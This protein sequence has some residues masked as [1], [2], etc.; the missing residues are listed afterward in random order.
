M[1][2]LS[3][4]SE[5]VQGCFSIYNPASCENIFTVTSKQR[6]KQRSCKFRLRCHP[7]VFP[8]VQPID[9]K[10]IGFGS[11]TYGA[12]LTGCLIHKHNLLVVGVVSFYRLLVFGLKH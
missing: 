1:K 8:G 3:E 10:N 9:E 12:G 2:P 4:E 6:T 5:R 11:E 7:V